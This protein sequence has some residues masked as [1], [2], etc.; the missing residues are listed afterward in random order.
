MNEQPSPTPDTGAEAVVP[1]VAAELALLATV[2]SEREGAEYDARRNSSEDYGRGRTAV[3]MSGI[4][5]E[6]VEQTQ[7]EP[8]LFDAADQAAQEANQAAVNAA[9][10]A[11]VRA[12]LPRSKPIRRNS[13]IGALDFYTAHTGMPKTAK[14][15]TGPVTALRPRVR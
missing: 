15:Y 6:P 3:K 4:K 8:S 11:E 2:A 7:I 13:A 5:V 1:G 14:P 9:G 10:L 12:K